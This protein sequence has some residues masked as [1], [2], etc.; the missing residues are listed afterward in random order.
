M[1]PTRPEASAR[2]PRMPAGGGPPVAKCGESG[3]RPTEGAL[4]RNPVATRKTRWRIG[5]FHHHVEIPVFRA[6]V[7]IYLNRLFH[8]EAQNPGRTAAI[9]LNLQLPRTAPSAQSAPDNE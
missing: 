7:G 5:R 1:L 4:P 8:C 2:T 3:L 9:R 6:L